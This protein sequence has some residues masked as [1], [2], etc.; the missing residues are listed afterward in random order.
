MSRSS[1]I[2]ADC[3]AITARSW[4]WTATA[5]SAPNSRSSSLA[6]WPFSGAKTSSTRLPR[7]SATVRAFSVNAPSTSRE[8]FSNSVRTKSALTSACSRESTRAPI[9]IASTS[10]R[11]GRRRPPRAR[12]RARRRS[13]RDGEAVG[14]D[15]V[16]EDGDAGRAEGRGGFHDSGVARYARRPDGT[17][18]SVQPTRSRPAP[19]APRRSTSSRSTSAWPGPARHS[20]TSRSTGLRLAL[21]DR[22]DGAVGAVRRP[23]RDA[24]AVRPRAA[25][26]RGRRRL[27]P[28]RVRAPACGRSCGYRRA[29]GHDRGARRRHHGARGRRDR[30]RREHASCCTAA[31]SRRRSPAPA[32]RRSTRSRAGPRRS[33]SARR[34]RRR[35]ARCRPAGSSTPPRWSSAARP[36]AEIIRRATASTLRARRRARRAQPRAGRV[37]HRRRRLPA[38]RGGADR[39]RGGAPPPRRRLARSSGSSSP[40]TASRRAPRSRPRSTPPLDR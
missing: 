23:A 35:P 34:S 31:A 9:S 15:D 29:D 16:A 25:A 30:Q 5:D 22:L 37:R 24:L 39:G 32:G 1:R 33:A 27:A 11:R 2:R 36:S 4:C 3:S 8:T 17:Q 38:R 19:R 20:S 14:D 21:E 12:A 40:S 13:G 26:S 28:A 7:N 6:R 18:A 10:T